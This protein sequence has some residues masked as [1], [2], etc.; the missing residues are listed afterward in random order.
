MVR[1]SNQQSQCQQEEGEQNEG[2]EEISIFFVLFK[3]Q[4]G[5]PST[6]PTVGLTGDE[7]L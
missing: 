4:L 2:T 3:V 7:Y 6:V 1:K 5:I